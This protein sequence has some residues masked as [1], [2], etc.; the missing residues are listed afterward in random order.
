MSTSFTTPN[1]SSTPTF[2]GTSNYASDLQQALTRAEA[3]AQ[4]PITQLQQEQQSVQSQISELS[5][6]QTNFTALTT[7]IKNIGTASSGGSFSANVSDSSVATATVQGNVLPGN[8]S[9]VITNPG[10]HT[11]ALSDNS[12]PKVTDPTS[13]SISTASSFTLT[14]NGSPFTIVPASNTLD[15][16]ASAI[17]NASAGVA[18]TVVNIGSPQSPDYRLSL[19][20]S[21]LG[22][23]TI[24]LTDGTPAVLLDTISTGVNAVYTVNGQPSGGVS[25]TS[26]T[27]TIA[28]GLTVNLLADGTTNVSVTQ[29]PGSLQNAL[30]AFATAYNNAI[31]EVNTNRGQTGGALTGNSVISTLASTL[32]NVTGYFGSSGNI[33]SLADLGLTFDQ[34]GHLKFDST[35]L[36]NLSSAQ[37]SDISNFLGSVSG[38]GFLGTA[39]NAL[40]A[41]SDP[42]TGLIHQDSTSLQQTSASEQ[43][44]IDSQT[45]QLQLL[46]TTLTTQMNAADA[47]ISSLEQQSSFFTNLFATQNALNNGKV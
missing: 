33:L 8:Y 38:G 15:A 46:Q 26:S 4:L 6:L 13:T 30:S 37:Y 24:A 36:S 47:L 25:S 3:I 10:S 27:V 44:Q 22:G 5:K 9:I 2:N 12:R 42:V 7:A 32:Q 11:S 45:Q 39:S 21:T 16:L 1:S 34:S 20:S 40:S 31:D 17:N 35:A 18:A 23:T 19:Q 28:P 43:S 14:V 29:S 41:L